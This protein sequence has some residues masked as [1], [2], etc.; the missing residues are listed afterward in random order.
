MSNEADR[1]RRRDRERLVAD[2]EAART[3]RRRRGLALRSP[4]S[5]P[6]RFRR[7]ES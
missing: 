1:R 3:A 6:I 2:L 4:A 7:S 5:L